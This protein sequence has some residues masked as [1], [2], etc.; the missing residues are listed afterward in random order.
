MFLA[1]IVLGF[2]FEI[3]FYL[4]IFYFPLINQIL[5][6]LWNIYSFGKLIVL[7]QRIIIIIFFIWNPLKWIKS[8]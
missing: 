4:K 6:T 7:S 3:I 1:V 2:S 5:H 8:Y